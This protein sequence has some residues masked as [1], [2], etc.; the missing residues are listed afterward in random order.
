MLLLR[1][2]AQKTENSIVTGK[3]GVLH[4]VKLAIALE[5][6]SSVLLMKTAQE[7]RIKRNCTTILKICYYFYLIFYIKKTI[8]NIS[9]PLNIFKKVIKF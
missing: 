4:P 7:V 5:E 6:K 2:S 9:K 8:D 3:I 1:K